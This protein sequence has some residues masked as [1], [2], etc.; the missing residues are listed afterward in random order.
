M[1]LCVSTKDQWLAQRAYHSI[2]LIYEQAP[3]KDS[4]QS[5][6]ETLVSRRG[7]DDIADGSLGATPTGPAPRDGRA[8]YD[9]PSKASTATGSA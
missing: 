3:T 8:I 7:L 6:Y 5:R 2:H 4:R 9:F 1:T